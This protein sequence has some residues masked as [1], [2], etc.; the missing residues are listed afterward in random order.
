MERARQRE[1]DERSNLL[2][3]NDRIRDLRPDDICLRAKWL[4]HIPRPMAIDM[5][6]RPP[7]L[8]GHL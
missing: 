4:V 3:L 7:I 1:Q 2:F 5:L 6:E 8:M